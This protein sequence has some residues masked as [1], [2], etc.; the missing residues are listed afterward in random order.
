MSEKLPPQAP[1][2]T[3]FRL[4]EYFPLRLQNLRPGRPLPCHLYLRVPFQ[5]R[6]ALA[7]PQGENFPEP[8]ASSDGHPPRW[9]FFPVA[10]ISALLNYLVDGTEAHL[11]RPD[12]SHYE[13]LAFLYDLL[14]VWIQHLYASPASLS[15]A[16]LKFATAL[17]HQAKYYLLSAPLPDHLWASLRRHDSHL[18][19]HSVN[20]FFFA[21]HYSLSQNWPEEEVRDFGLASLWHD[22][23]MTSLPKNLTCKAEGLTELDKQYLRHH[24][25]AGRKILAEISEMPTEVLTVVAQHHENFD[26]SGYPQGLA[27]KEL[28][29]W[30]RLLRII[31]TFESLT[32]LRPWR[33]PCNTAQALTLMKSTLKGKEIYDPLQLAAFSQALPFASG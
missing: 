33:P 22:I 31:D 30:A 8:F 20:V 24:P 6:L 14:L 9:A 2:L 21:L 19:T 10:D 7:C 32:S 25:V 11:N 1:V 28:H 5:G 27:E 13:K 29:P 16:S 3:T 23:G 17:I 18:Y 15:S 26:G 12:L 4:E